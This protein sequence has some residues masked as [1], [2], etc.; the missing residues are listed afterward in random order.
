[1]VESAT[2][3]Y[4][5]L[6]CTSTLSITIRNVQLGYALNAPNAGDHFWVN[7]IGF[8]VVNL[9]TIEYSSDR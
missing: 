8:A 3:S 4:L 5:P 7:S 6:T 1:M 2:L 9:R